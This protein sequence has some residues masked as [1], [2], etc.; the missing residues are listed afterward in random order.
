MPAQKLREIK[1]RTQQEKEE[2]IGKMLKRWGHVEGLAQR[3]KKALV[4]KVEGD[5]VQSE[6]ST[7]VWYEIDFATW[8][9]TGH[10]C[11]CTDYQT[12]NA[13]MAGRRRLCKHTI[14]FALEN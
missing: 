13:P 10:T 9:N 14:A 2:M 6:T 3:A 11:S 1:M 8:P 5:K 12:K 7:D 4:L